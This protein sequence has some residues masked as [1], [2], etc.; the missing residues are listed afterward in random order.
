MK[1]FQRGTV[2]TE[3]LLKP[4]RI[5]QHVTSK[6]ENTEQ[7][8]KIGPHTD[9]S[10]VNLRIL[11]QSTL[12]TSGEK[13]ISQGITNLCGAHFSTGILEDSVCKIKLFTI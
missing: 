1:G 9:M 8:T 13:N 4:G 3:H 7:G 5:C 11:T 10:P 12:K 6:H 2:R